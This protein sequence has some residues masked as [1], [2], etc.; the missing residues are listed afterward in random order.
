MGVLSKAWGG[1]R[2]VIKK[3]ARGI[4]TLAK[5]VAYATPGGKQAWDLS[6]KIGEGAM[7]VVGKVV[8]AI[9]P[10][11]MIAL[12]ILAPYAA[13]LWSAFGAAAAAAGGFWGTVGTAIYTAGNWVGATLGSMTS[14][15]SKGISALSSGAISEAGSAV[16]KGF[17]DAF[18]GKAG[19]AGVAAGQASAAALQSAATAAG[20][21]VW[22]QAADQ[23]V[24]NVTGGGQITADQANKQIE[25][26]M[27]GGGSGGSGGSGGAGGPTDQIANG[28][29][30]PEAINVDANAIKTQAPEVPSVGADPA[31]ISQQLESAQVGG[32]DQTQA[33]TQPNQVKP[34]VGINKQSTMSNPTA[35]VDFSPINES[36]SPQSTMGSKGAFQTPTTVKPKPTEGSSLMGKALQA[37]SS[38]LGGDNGIIE[39][40]PIYGSNPQQFHSAINGRGGGGSAG[41]DFLSQNILMALQNQSQRMIEGFG[42]YR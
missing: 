26:D 29:Q 4:K 37:A 10:V 3:A 34:T 22:K 41:G 16:V 6:T 32:V 40:P 19:M 5:K 7:K 28:P 42:T 38:A 9:G 27:Q 18:T 21:S 36:A 1:I 2:K 25:A 35:N 31:K 11:G 17:A 23:I 20:Q 15:I 13:P 14:G 12:S 39:L 33:F 24:S 8:N 30:A